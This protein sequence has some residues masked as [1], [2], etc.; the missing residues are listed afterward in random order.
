MAV[1]TRL[2]FVDDE[3]N[4]RLT[5][6]AILRMHGFEVSVAA[7]V[8]EALAMINSQSFEVLLSDLNI[9]QPGDGFVVVSAMRRT[10][11]EAVTMIIT[12]FPAFESAL[13]AIRNQVDDSITKPAEIP[14]LVEALRQKVVNRQPR[15]AIALKRISA[16]IREN[17]DEIE[18]QWLD[19]LARSPEMN[20]IQLSRQAWSNEFPKILLATM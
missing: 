6:P 9:G 15:R 7:T 1:K 3:P 17:Q 11:P 19:E 8:Q 10:H 12:G 16:I 14:K 2:L 20:S 13:E 5:L 4:S 18:Q